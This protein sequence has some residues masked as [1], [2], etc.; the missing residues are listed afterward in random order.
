MFLIFDFVRIVLLETVLSSLKTL[1]GIENDDGYTI[2]SGSKGTNQR[3]E[4]DY[5]SKQTLK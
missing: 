3:D 1:P 2:E 5:Y 4:V